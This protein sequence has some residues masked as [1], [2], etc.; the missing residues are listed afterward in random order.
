M[1][2]LTEFVPDGLTAFLLARIA[3]DETTAREATS[4]P[5]VVDPAGDGI[6]AGS[7]DADGY[8]DTAVVI[9]DHGAYPPDEATAQHIARWDPARV[10][11]ECEAKR[12]IIDLADESVVY[13]ATRGSDSKEEGKMWMYGDVLKLLALPYADHPDYRDEW[14]PW[15]TSDAR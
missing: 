15:S 14:R 3:E 13:W 2:D 1:I 10:L 8:Y 11:A 7:P 9:S 5:W 4:S 12:R 6:R